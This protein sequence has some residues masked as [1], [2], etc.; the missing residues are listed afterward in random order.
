VLVRD[1]ADEH[2]NLKTS[3]GGSVATRSKRALTVTN[4]SRGAFA[5]RYEYEYSYSG[6]DRPRTRLDEIL[7][8]KK[9]SPKRVTA[10]TSRRVLVEA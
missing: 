3:Q 2:S 4:S 8:N 7:G 5:C 6:P 1:W 10:T 9:V